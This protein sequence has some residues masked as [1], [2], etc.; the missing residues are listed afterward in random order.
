LDI[1][2]DSTSEDIHFVNDGGDDDEFDNS[3]GWLV[4]LRRR[5]KDSVSLMYRDN[6]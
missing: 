3:D 1:I 5:W 4:D 6:A 2:G